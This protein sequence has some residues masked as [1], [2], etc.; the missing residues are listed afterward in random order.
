MSLDLLRLDSTC[1]CRMHHHEYFKKDQ[2]AGDS[3]AIT[4]YNHIHVYQI[5]A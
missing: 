3:I 4:V 1:K 5:V 2:D